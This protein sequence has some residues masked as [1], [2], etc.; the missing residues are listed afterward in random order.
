MSA[1]DR[2]R[3]RQQALADA[4]S[5]VNATEVADA[6]VALADCIDV[7]ERAAEHDLHARRILGQVRAYLYR[8]GYWKYPRKE[9]DT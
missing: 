1:L 8:R 7:L 5:A 2:Y 6:V 3:W 9:Q 4:Q